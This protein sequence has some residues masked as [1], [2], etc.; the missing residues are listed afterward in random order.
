MHRIARFPFYS[1]CG[2]QIIC[3]FGHTAIGGAGVPNATEKDIT[4]FVDAPIMYRHAFEIVTLND[5]QILP[6]GDTLQKCGFKIVAGPILNHLHGKEVYILLRD[7]S[8]ERKVEVER[9]KRENKE[10]N[11]K[12]TEELKNVTALRGAEARII[13]EQRVLAP[14]IRN[15]LTIEEWI[16]QDI[17]AD[18]MEESTFR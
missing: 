9:Q 3:N 2:G 14:Q 5:D 12:L 17:Q 13:N 8:I 15:R 16:D 6:V 4:K 1:C 11:K 7:N 10:K 18:A